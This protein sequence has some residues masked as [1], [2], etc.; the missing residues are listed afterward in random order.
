[1]AKK[2]LIFSLMLGFIALLSTL[3]V[4]EMIWLSNM[5]SLASNNKVFKRVLVRTSV[6]KLMSDR[7]NLSRKYRIMW[8]LTQK[9]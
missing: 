5:K 2:I 6:R 4:P 3:K 1:M 9:I 8:L 7:F